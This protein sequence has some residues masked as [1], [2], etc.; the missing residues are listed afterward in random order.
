MSKMCDNKIT[1]GQFID[2]HFSIA[3][4]TLTGYDVAANKTGTKY[5]SSNDMTTTWLRSDVEK[6]F[7]Y[8]WFVSKKRLKLIVE[9]DWNVEKRIQED[10]ERWITMINS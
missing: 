8:A 1:V 3:D 10:K 7:V 4:K 2:M 6:C 9:P 5:Y